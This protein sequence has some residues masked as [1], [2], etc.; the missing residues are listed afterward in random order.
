[1]TKTYPSPGSYHWQYP[2]LHWCG[3]EPKFSCTAGRQPHLAGQ[4]SREE[5]SFLRRWHLGAPLP[6]TLHGVRWHNLLLCIW[7]HWGMFESNSLGL[8]AWE[9]WVMYFYATINQGLK[10]L[11]TIIQKMCVLRLSFAAQV[12]SFILV[13]RTI[14]MTNL[15]KMEWFRNVLIALWARKLLHACG[16][17][18][19]N[20][21]NYVNTCTGYSNFQTVVAI[22]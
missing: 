2:R 9:I 6:Q 14:N 22:H 12:D 8:A 10:H 3:N 4:N 18:S 16:D 13:F 20:K 11:M 17:Y 7:L 1:M 19:W 5:D 15:P 21:M